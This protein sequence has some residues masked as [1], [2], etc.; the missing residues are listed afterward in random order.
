METEGGSA[1]EPVRPHSGSG[2]GEEEPTGIGANAGTSP[3]GGR[4]PAHTPTLPGSTHG[5]HP[6][7][8]HKGFV[9]PRSEAPTEKWNQAM[10]EVVSGLLTL[11]VQR[12]SFFEDSQRRP[13]KPRG[14]RP[15]EISSGFTL[16]H[17]GGGGPS[18][19][20]RRRPRP[21]VRAL[22]DEPA[23]PIVPL[24]DI[25]EKMIPTEE[26]YKAI[27]DS[28]TYALNNKDKSML[29]GQSTGLGRQKKD[30]TNSF[31]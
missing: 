19:R 4:D 27:L 25:P 11:L 15:T 10:V 18:R 8:T 7:E 14:R 5:G 28:E 13:H 6:R 3:T 22:H 9:A 16:D 29:G 17:S 2:S 20:G 12:L 23:G 1:T 21:V 30:V 31:V 26:R 24:R